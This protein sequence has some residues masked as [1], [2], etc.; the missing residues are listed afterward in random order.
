M[1]ASRNDNYEGDSPQRL[2]TTLFALIELLSTTEFEDLSV[3]CEIIVVDW[4]S[5]TDTLQEHE[6]HQRIQ[7]LL[8][9]CMTDVRFLVVSPNDAEVI[10]DKVPLSEVHALNLAAIQARN[11]YLLRLDQDTVV[12]PRFLR[13]LKEATYLQASSPWWCGRRE[14]SSDKYC[15]FV[16]DPNRCVL[17]EGT[18]FPLFGGFVENNYNGCGAV[19]VLGVPRSLWIRIGGYN[20]SLVYRAHMEI[21]LAS[22]LGQPFLNIADIVGT[23]FYHI[24][25]V[26]SQ[27][28]QI[29]QLNDQHYD[30]SN[31]QIVP[32]TET[33]TLQMIE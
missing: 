12:G 30:F 21:E 17:D 2:F 24:W 19:G 5:Q 26:N 10:C 14:S 3:R 1:Y 4:N 27:D 31:N 29:N 22:R 8:S 32:F 18:F 15:D 33:T 25:H 23:D 7:P 9:G 11:D 16:K 13:F 28:R 6:Y 20:T